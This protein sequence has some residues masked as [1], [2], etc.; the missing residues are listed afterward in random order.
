MT[1]NIKIRQATL[2][3]VDDIA[4]LRSIGFGSDEATIKSHV[5]NNSR[6]N[7]GHIIMANIDNEAVGTACVFPVDM[8]LGGVPLSNAAIASVT[9]HPKHRMQGVANAM[10]IDLLHRAANEGFAISTLF[11]A[12]HAMYHRYGYGAAAVWHAYSIDPQ[13]IPFFSEIENIRPFEDNDLTAIQSLY[14][15]TQLIQN[16]G[17]FYRSPLVWRKLI[18]GMADHPRRHIVVYDDNGIEGYICYEIDKQ[19]SFKVRE[20]IFH[21]DAAYRGLWAFMGS[22]VETDVER[23]DILASADCSLNQLLITPNDAKEHTHS[24]VFNDIFHGVSSFMLRVINLSQALTERFYPSAMMGERVIQ[25]A[26]PHLPQNQTPLRFRIVDGRGETHSADNETPD[27]RTDIVTFSQI[28][29]GFLPPV[30][31][32]RQGKLIADDDSVA[33]LGQAMAA[34]PLYIHQ[35][36]WF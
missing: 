15:G 1:T 31:A 8:W 24:W 4:R 20:I 10:M 19:G 14:R 18:A 25:I 11:P 16:D 21:T 2:T 5:L 6:Y 26:D 30:Q 33:W 27:I 36:D 9:T 13:N 3:D 17:R 34:K 29:C 22:R 28:Y 35:N 32:R 7:I 12:S 23:I